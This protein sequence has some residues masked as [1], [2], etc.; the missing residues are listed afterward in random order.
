MARTYLMVD[1][2]KCTGCRVCELICSV[3][4]EQEFRPSVSR[5]R[6]HSI[7]PIGEFPIV[8][9]QCSEPSCVEACPTN[10]LRKNEVNGSIIVDEELCI[11]CRACLEACPFKC[12]TIHPTTDIPIVCDLCGGKPVCVKFCPTGTLKF[13]RADREILKQQRLVA[14]KA[15]EIQ[16]K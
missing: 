7:Y 8:C 12:I 14:T 9:R 6:V 10:A 15:A 5:I 16:E 3:T 4:H 11:K 1:Q 2:K 13:A